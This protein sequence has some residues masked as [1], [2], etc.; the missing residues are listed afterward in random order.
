MNRKLAG[1]NTKKWVCVVSICVVISAIANVCQLVNLSHLEAN[2]QDTSQ[3]LNNYRNLQ[4]IQIE[5]V[6]DN[7]AQLQA[8][9]SDSS[10]TRNQILLRFKLSSQKLADDYKTMIFQ[11]CYAP[12]FLVSGIMHR[13]G[14]STEDMDDLLLEPDSNFNI[15]DNAFDGVKW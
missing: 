3:R 7:C 13:E 9:V 15:R 10:Y 6:K 4:A 14:V 5:A 8:S 1:L 12:A 2:A 11:G